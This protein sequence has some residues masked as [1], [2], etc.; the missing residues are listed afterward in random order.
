[1]HLIFTISSDMHMCAD[2]H[3]HTQIVEHVLNTIMLLDDQLFLTF[4]FLQ[5]KWALFFPMLFMK[6]VSYKHQD[7]KENICMAAI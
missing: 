2:A 4:K 1:M 7:Y 5:K 6:N 3:S